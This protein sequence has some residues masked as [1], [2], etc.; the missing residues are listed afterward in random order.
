MSISLGHIRAAT[1]LSY[2]SFDLS[3]ASGLI[4]VKFVTLTQPDKGALTSPVE[5]HRT[6]PDEIKSDDVTRHF[7]K[8]KERKLNL[9]LTLNEKKKTGR[10][11]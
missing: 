2:I 4:L 5:E 10:A 1:V 11:F 6:V 7:Q 3:Q 9:N 8:V